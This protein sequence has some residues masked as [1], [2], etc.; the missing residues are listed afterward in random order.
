MIDKRISLQEA[1]ELVPDRQGRLSLGG[2]T[3][4]RRPVAMT[5]ALIS[6][7]QETGFPEQL[8]LI[9]FTSGIES[10]LL[11]GMKMVKAIRSCYTG[12]EAFGLAPFFT[13][14]ANRGE[15]EIIEETEA[16]LALGIRATLSGVG[17]IPSYSWQGTDLLK[18]RP[19]VKTVPDPY[20]GDTLTAFPAIECD[21]AVIHAL[22]SDVSGNAY[23]G[24]NW[25]I[26][27]ELALLAS[28]VIVTTEEVVDDIKE[29]HVFAPRV[30][31][32]VEAPSGAWPTSC[33]PNYPLDGHAVLRYANSAASDTFPSLLRD[34]MERHKF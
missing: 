21:V 20:S 28:T 19:D 18:L 3:L 6:R 24:K 10:D 5:L 29:A 27:R 33:H 25:G 2:I 14:A 11:I 12:L 32:V 1:A 23:I 30:A 26:D 13:E 15:I 31:A 34:W 7:M 17:F 22:R 4:Y 8:T 9:N 16:S